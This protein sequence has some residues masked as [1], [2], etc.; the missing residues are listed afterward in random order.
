MPGNDRSRDALIIFS[1]A[2][3]T[4]MG[5][6][7]S[8]IV[9]VSLPT[10]ARYFDASLS[11]ISRLIMRASSEKTE[12]TVF[13]LLNTVTYLGATI[14]VVLFETIFSQIVHSPG[15]DW[16]LA[17]P[18]FS[19]ENLATGFRHVFFLLGL[20]SVAGWIFSYLAGSGGRR[21]GKGVS[22]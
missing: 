21:K 6:L 3:A 12:G 7:D 20:I 14:G 10:M 18:G 2:L 8:Y 11:D 16:T 13:G 15:S 9:N 17:G 4:F 1:V 5:R 19:A 22:P